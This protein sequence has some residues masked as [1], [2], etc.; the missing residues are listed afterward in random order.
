M[1]L[2]GSPVSFHLTKHAGRQTVDAKLLIGVSET[3]SE[4]VSVSC[5][6]RNILGIHFDSD[7]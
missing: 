6:V 1:F 5:L 7:T 4:S 2:I 3:V